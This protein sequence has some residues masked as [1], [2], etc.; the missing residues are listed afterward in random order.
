M[1]R[2]GSIC[3]VYGSTPI[4]PSAQLL[5]LFAVLPPLL[6]TVRLIYG[7]LSTEPP[8][9]IFL[10]FVLSVVLLSLLVAMWFLSAF[11]GI[12]NLTTLYYDYVL[13]LWAGS[14][15]GSKTACDPDLG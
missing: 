9:T 1:V 13:G 5:A 3:F 8:S 7:F 6:S 15:L 11:L 2:Y 14:F 4:N 12:S 10:F